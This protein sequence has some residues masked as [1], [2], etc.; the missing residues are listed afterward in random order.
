MRTKQFGT[1]PLLVLA[2]ILVATIV[3]GMGVIIFLDKSMIAQTVSQAETRKSA[4]SEPALATDTTQTAPTL[5]AAEDNE[6]IKKALDAS[7]Q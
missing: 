7:K 3:I 1:L 2:A 4:I 5:G 6:A